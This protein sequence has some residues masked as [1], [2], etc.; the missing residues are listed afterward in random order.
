METVKE[1]R[2]LEQFNEIAEDCLNGNWKYAAKQC[3][4]YGFYAE[5]LISYDRELKLFSDAYDVAILIELT[6]EFR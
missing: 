3:V 2:T 1:Y 4:K 6:E 5:D